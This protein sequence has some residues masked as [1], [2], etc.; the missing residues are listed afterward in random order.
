MY[1]LPKQS[2]L[3]VIKQI[4]HNN[5]SKEDNIKEICKA[6]LNEEN[7]SWTKVYRALKEVDCDD[8]ADLVKNDF[9][10]DFR[11]TYIAMYVKC[12]YSFYIQGGLPHKVKAVWL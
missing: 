6:I 4:R 10:T 9:L 12:Q 8:L 5:G 2:A 7:P 11:D 3:Q 1:F